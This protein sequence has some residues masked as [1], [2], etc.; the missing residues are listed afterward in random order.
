MIKAKNHVA[1]ALSLGAVLEPVGVGVGVGVDA[2][3]DAF[4]RSFVGAP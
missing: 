1:W 4:R 3:V 2:D